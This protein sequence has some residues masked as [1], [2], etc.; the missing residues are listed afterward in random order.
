MYFVFLVAEEHIIGPIWI[1]YVDE[2]VNQ[3]ANDKEEDDGLGWEG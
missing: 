2:I 1:L 3:A